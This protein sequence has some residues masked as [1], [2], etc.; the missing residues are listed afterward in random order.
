MKT[1]IIPFQIV[2]PVIE[3]KVD[4]TYFPVKKPSGINY[5]FLV[6]MKD[7]PN[8]QKL[9]QDVL[10]EFGL[11][12]DVFR[13]VAEEIDVMIKNDVIVCAKGYQ[14]ESFLT[15]S[16]SDFHFTTRGEEVF[17]RQFIQIEKEK[18][19]TM[20]VYYTPYPFQGQQREYTLKPPS[21]PSLSL[22]NPNL[23]AKAFQ[24][25][26]INDVQS[27]RK[28][29][30][31]FSN[32]ELGLQNQERVGQIF[33]KEQN[34]LLAMTTID[35]KITETKIIDFHDLPNSIKSL[36]TIYYTDDLFKELVLWNISK[37]APSL[38]AEELNDLNDVIQLRWPDETIKPSL[39]DSL[40]LMITAK[41][42]GSD[43]NTLS[44][45][46]FFAQQF[47]NDTYIR[48]DRSQ[49]ISRFGRGLVATY[50]VNYNA[51]APLVLN[52]EKTVTKSML[53]SH[54]SVLIKPINN[55]Q[56]DVVK[57]V[58]TIENALVDFQVSSEWI[59]HQIKSQT[60]PLAFILACISLIAAYPAWKSLLEQQAI[61]LIDRHLSS[62]QSLD[63][64]SI[65]KNYLT[66]AKFAN[67]SILSLL[68]Q[69]K[70]NLKSLP[71]QA[72]YEKLVEVNLDPKDV[73]IHF[74][75]LSVYIQQILNNEDINPVDKL[76]IELGKLG[77]RFQNLK[78]LLKIEKLTDVPF[79][80]GFD[81]ENY[82]KSYAGFLQG[83]E[84]IKT[85]QSYLPNDEIKTL[86]NFQLLFNESAI[87][88]RFLKERERSNTVFT[89]AEVERY[90]NAPSIE[91]LRTIVI[92]LTCI[93]E[94]LGK[95]FWKAN[96]RATLEEHIQYFY[97][98][99]V[100]NQGEK[101]D[102]HQLRLWRVSLVH[103]TVRVK[104]SDAE[105]RNYAELV[106][107]LSQKI[108]AL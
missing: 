38:K 64:I 35:M 45:E 97:E 106:L 23:W 36:V 61:A 19:Q 66:L 91:K 87:Y 74:N 103:P 101:S 44:F 70:K 81:Y 73:L 77:Q 42:S 102:L 94:E 57:A 62:L 71:A 3:V 9:V 43:K 89:L 68:E 92:E 22:T 48:I 33:L 21:L 108:N 85:F 52:Y 80:D 88:A 63:D 7:Y 40:G 84:Y 47:I 54:L 41:P 30:D 90:I 79:D 5:M 93:V 39:L 83:M 2:V 28:Q 10:F 25:A 86:T 75:P 34:V 105:L 100:I 16:L 8:K 4:F 18:D 60:N 27:F 55:P 98:Q 26:K 49:Q 20:T 31:R 14:I 32:A 76:T 104:H 65:F 82:L 15:Y 95:A 17:E 51:D 67:R 46:G 96:P 72:V 12:K 78:T 107:T 99:K 69:L 37:H 11:A 24:K 6:L 59:L 13:I 53:I 29:F 1:F 58:Y 50:Q 56:S